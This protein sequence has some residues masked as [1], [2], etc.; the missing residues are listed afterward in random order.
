MGEVK[1]EFEV[2]GFGEE[3][4][5]GYDDAIKSFEMLRTK[6]LPKSTTLEQLETIVNELFNEIKKSY[7]HPPCQLGAKVIIRA[8]E[9]NDQVIYLG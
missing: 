8:K 6:T 9:K 7:D 4:C 3:K 1:V 2:K 5:D